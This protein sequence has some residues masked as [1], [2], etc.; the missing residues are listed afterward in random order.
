MFMYETPTLKEV[1]SFADLTRGDLAGYTF[2]GGHP[3]FIY[4]FKG[5]EY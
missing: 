1:G 4:M 5:P 2:D 3:P